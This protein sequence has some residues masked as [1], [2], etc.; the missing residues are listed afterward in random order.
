MKLLYL[1]NSSVEQ[2]IKHKFVHIVLIIAVMI[3]AALL[4]YVSSVT[5][6]AV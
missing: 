1:I 2:L 6:M 5:D 4:N 3:S